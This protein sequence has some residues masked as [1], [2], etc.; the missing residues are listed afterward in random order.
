MMGRKW[1]E[2]GEKERDNTM[3]ARKETIERKQNM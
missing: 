1:T 3:I 2:K